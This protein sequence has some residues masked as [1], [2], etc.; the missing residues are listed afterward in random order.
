MHLPHTCINAH[1]Q[2]FFREER[3]AG[4]SLKCLLTKHH[5]AMATLQP[6]GPEHYQHALQTVFKP[7]AVFKCLPM[8]CG[9]SSVQLLC[10]TPHLHAWR[11]RRV[12]C[13]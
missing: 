9:H 7:L 4:F 5:Q 12:P 8:A 11:P 13:G 1:T 6:Y 3:D 10:T 2:A